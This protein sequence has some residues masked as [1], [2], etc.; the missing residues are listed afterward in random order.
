MINRYD[1]NNALM[2]EHYPTALTNEVLH[3]LLRGQVLDC[4]G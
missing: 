2:L 3:D 1:S 4:G